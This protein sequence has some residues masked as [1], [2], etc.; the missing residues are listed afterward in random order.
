MGEN[1]PEKR[2]S[3]LIDRVISIDEKKA[4]NYIVKGLIFAV[5][6][7]VIAMISISVAGNAGDWTNLQNQQNQIAFWSQRIGYQDFLERQ[8][9]ILSVRYWMQFQEAIVAN[10]AKLGV[11]LGLIF[12]IIGFTAHAMD[13]NR[14]ERSRRISYIIVGVIA[15]FLI[16]SMISGQLGFVIG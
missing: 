15:A 2:K 1:M 6:F 10:I 8:Q 16:S 9:Q 13:T 3:N 7:A 11:Y 5:I 14:D 4:T 12:V